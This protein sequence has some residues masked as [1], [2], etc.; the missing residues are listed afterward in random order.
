MKRKKVDLMVKDVGLENCGRLLGSD[1][2]RE[3]KM[4]KRKHTSH[5]ASQMRSFGFRVTPLMQPLGISE[6]I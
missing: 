1:A 3:E 6:I 4:G 5:S 2:F